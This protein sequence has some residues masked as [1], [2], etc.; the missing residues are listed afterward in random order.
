M[1]RF[2]GWGEEDVSFPV[3]VDAIAYLAERVGPSR[4]PQDATLADL[5]ARVPPSR[6]AEHSLPREVRTSLAADERILHAS[7][8]S[9]PEWIAVRGGTLERAP[10]A[11][12]YPESRSEVRALLTF[13]QQTRTRLIPYG[14]GTSVVGHLTAPAGEQAVLTVDMG[15]MNRMLALQKGERL[16]TFQ[17][18]VRGSHLEAELQA[19]DFTL[20]HYPQS[21]EYS[22]LGGWVATRSVGQFSLGYGRIDSLFAG[23]HLET[24]EGPLDV[25]SFPASAAGPD[26]RQWILGS[27]GR[28]GI[29]TECTVRVS[30]V[31]ERE[32]VHAAFFQGEDTA[33]AAVRDLAQADV[34]L[35][36]IRLSL[37]AETATTLALSGH[38]RVLGVLRRFLQ[39]R[40]VKKDACL[41]LY[42]AVGRAS[43]VSHRILKARRII[44]GLKGVSVGERIGREWHRTRFRTPYLRNSLWNLGYAIDTLETAVTWNRCVPAVAAIETALKVALRPFGE[45]VHVFTHLSHVYPQGSSIYVTYVFRLGASPEETLAR[46]KALKQGASAAVVK[47]GGTISHQHGVGLDHRPYLQAEK[48]IL[49]VNMIRGALRA[50][51]PDEL[52]NPG[53]LME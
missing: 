8:Q 6:I 7:G 23:G 12:A 3:N 5:L 14:G 22:T 52:M 25:P 46:W 21:F 51:D 11:V 47:S 24:P 29:L 36:M 28:L 15:H 41:L 39:L 53:K 18:G 17:A 30:P 1:R 26:L 27:E 2:N 19:N 50:V 40:G 33:L 16:A 13:A 43:D 48:G 35:T 44:A 20:G 49:G 42:G 32:T 4:A 10:D 31:P 38:S 9:L 34:A 45:R 37:A